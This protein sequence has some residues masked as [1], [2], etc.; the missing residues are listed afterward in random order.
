LVVQLVRVYARPAR[1]ESRLRAGPARPQKA[2]RNPVFF[3]FCL[4]RLVVQLIRMHPAPRR[5][6]GIT[7]RAACVWSPAVCRPTRV[8]AWSGSGLWFIAN[9]F[10]VVVL[11]TGLN[12]LIISF[13][14]GFSN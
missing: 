12:R 3:R 13:L 1:F 6:A 11:Y 7:H 2:R 14:L 4:F 10:V 5:T 9:L 8:Q